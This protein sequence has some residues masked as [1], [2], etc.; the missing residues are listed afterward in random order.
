MLKREL[1]VS[2][3][4]IGILATAVVKMM[5]PGR[6]HTGSVVMAATN[7]SSPPNAIVAENC[8]PGNPSSEWDISGA[9]DSTIQ[10]FATD[11]SVNQGGVVNFKINTPANGYRLDIYR[12]GY[13][14]GNGARKVAS[15]SYSG[16]QNQPAC[17]TN[18]GTGLLDCGNWT[19][20]ASWT[21]PSSAISGIYFARAVRTDTGGASHI[22]FIVRNDTSHSDILFQTSDLTWQAYN[23]YGGKNLY[24]CG[25]FDLSCRAFKVSYNRPFHTRVF[26]PESWVFNAEYPMVRWL[27]ANGY[28]ISYSTGVDAERNAALIRNHKVWM[29]NGHDEYWSGGERASVQAARDAG[30]HLAFFSGN[31]MFWKTRWENSIDGS[32]TPYR[33]LVC[34]KETHANAVIDPADPPTWTGTWRDPRFSPPADGGRPENAL[35]GT[36]FR[37]N[38]GQNGTIT[39]PQA[40]GKMRF[41]RNT[42]VATLGAG[43]VATLAPGTIGAEFDDDEDNGFRPAGLFELSSTSFTD[44]SNVLL[45]YGSTYGSGTVVHKMTLYKAPGGAIVFAAGTYQWSWGLDSNHD[46]SSLGSTTDVRMQQATVNLFADLGV[47]PASLQTGLTAATASSDTV[48]PGST[49]TA[50]AAGSNLPLGTPVTITGTAADT[51]GG[52]VAAVEV[53]VDGGTTWHPAT[54]RASWSYNWTPATSGSVTIKSRSADDSGNLEVPGAGVTVTAGSGGGGGTGCTS[55]C[56]IWPATATPG[57]PDGGPD[58]AVELGVKFRADSNGTISGIR[59]YKATTNTGTHVGNLWLYSTGQLLASATFSGETASGWQQVNFS[60]PVSITANTIYV[61]S[62]HANNGHYSDD[63]N[64]FGGAGLDNPPLHALQDGVSGFNGAYAYG[65]SSTFP[66]QGFNSSNYWVDVV[67]SSGSAP[68]LSSIAVTPTNPTIQAGL[69]QQFTATGTYSDNSTQNITNQVTWASSNQSAATINATGLAT[70]IAAGNSTISATKGSVTGSTT[71]TVQPVPVKITTTSLPNGVV[72]TAYSA[73]LAA[74]GGTSPYTWS[75][76]GSG[77]LPGSLILN[78]SGNITG[79]PTSSGTFNFSVQATD[80]ANPPG[81]ASANLS[82]TIAATPPPLSV[83]ATVPAN[84][85]TG[86]STSTTVSATFNNPLN[87]TT[88]NASTFTLTAGSTAVSGSYSVTGGNTAT[89]TPSSSLAASTTYTATLSTGIK[90]VNGGAL[91]SAVIWTFT[92]AVATGC[93]NNCTIWPAAAVPARLDDGPD[94]PVEIGVKFQADTTGAISGIRFYKASTN[95][96]THVGNLWSSGGQLLASATFTGETASGWQQVNFSSPVSITANTL[97]VASYHTNVGHYADD[98]NFFAT[99]GVDNAPLHALQNGLSGFNGVYAYGSGSTFPNQGFNSSNYWVDVVF[100]SGPAPPNTG[101]LGPASNAAVTVNAGDNS[102]FETTPANAQTAVDGQFAVDANSGTNTNTSCTNAGKDKHDFFT[103]NVNL[104][105]G[106]AIQGIEVRLDAKVSSTANSPVM[107]AQL[108]W[109]GGT[110]WTAAQSTPTLTTATATYILGGSA[111]TWGR[112]WALGD[113]SNANFKVRVIDVAASTA[114]TFSL[115]WIAVRV[116]YQ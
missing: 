19:S 44:S 112:P 17:L 13:Y 55:N 64:Y 60:A 83:T 91:A 114:R 90:D 75:L 28:D 46:R 107:C 65:A 4:A 88:I 92:T 85:T 52:V 74:S 12:M 106:V 45:D 104:P 14:G 35:V 97:Y 26:E 63:V 72:G 73:T 56:T 7:C 113:F 109:D 100:S 1:C 10:G 51:G 39:V 48:A 103:Y 105:A 6:S 41:W 22:V 27:E 111:N 71:L 18:S 66:T 3:I 53:S 77:A 68:T 20:Q 54:G 78:A 47:Q 36:L 37:M 38:G 30:V 5:P 115:D 108:S 87:A 21:V 58:S 61:A 102:G 2:L 33:T 34:Y 89:F 32:S 23:D 9:G 50:P 86:V 69:T 79:T 8:L 76:T 80:S 29:S 43:Q 42:S 82:I 94:S 98:Q 81:T 116:T 24:G 16:P 96:G 15:L 93:T 11:I 99:A 62:Y 59:F 95:T 84:G 101:F 31:T 49:I 57:T 67:F 40:D 70:G 110:T 25:S